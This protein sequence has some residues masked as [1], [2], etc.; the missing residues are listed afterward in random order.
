M[1]RIAKLSSKN[2]ASIPSAVREVLGLHP[3]DQLVFEVE[4]QTVTLHRY[5][6]LEELAGSV[7]V[8]PDVRGLSWTEIRERAWTLPDPPRRTSATAKR[9]KK[10]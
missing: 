1:R 10:R 8:P 4:G 7:P 3:G 6:R 9:I 5:P 2:Q